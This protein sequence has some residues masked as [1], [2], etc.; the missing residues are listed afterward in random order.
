LLL[1]YNN[2]FKI[3]ETK[4]LFQTKFYINKS[5]PPKQKGGYSHNRLSIKFCFCL[6]YFCFLLGH[7]A[8]FI[9][10]A[11]KLVGI[12]R[13]KIRNAKERKNGL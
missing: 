12:D 3:N 5:A 7:I 8:Y 9:F 1:F 13:Y 6:K 11:A 2:P 4:Y 10:R